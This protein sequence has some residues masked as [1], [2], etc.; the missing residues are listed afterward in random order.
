MV[1][2]HPENPLIRPEDI[3]PVNPGYKVIGAFNAGAVK[4]KDEVILLLRIAEQPPHGT[5]EEVAP[6]FLTEQNKVD[7]FRVQKQDPAY[8]PIDSRLFRYKGEVYLTSIS[9]LRVARSKDGR[10]FQIEDRP[11]LDAA[12]PLEAFGVEDPRITPLHD[13]YYVNYTAVS[14]AGI[15]TALSVTPDFV[16]FRRLGI[17]FA[18]AN[19]DVTIFPERI[20]G[21]YWCYHR[22]SGGHMGGAAMWVADSNDLLHWGTHQWLCAGRPGKWDVRK[23]GGGAVPIKTSKGWL[24]IYHG[25]DDQERY[26]L[27]L[28]LA[29]LDNP[30]NILA[31]SAEPILKPETPYETEG[32][33]GQVVFTCG[34]ITEPDGRVVIYY[35]AGDDCIAAAETSI[36]EL[37]ASLE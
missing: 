1:K 16:D 28:L 22:P 3:A 4:V 11:A 14:P 29:D 19:R 6:V 26:S 9:H 24:S 13:E 36:D 35:G 8:E 10:N 21:R 34:A 37:L 12:R 5:D 20:N 18:P 33:F 17:I 15:T 7:V 25:V 27:G 2:R 30:G 23:V 31:R 32:F